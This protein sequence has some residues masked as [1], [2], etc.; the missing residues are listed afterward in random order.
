MKEVSITVPLKRVP[1]Q[2]WYLALLI[3]KTKVSTLDLGKYRRITCEFSNEIQ[4]H[5]ALMHDGK[6]NFFINLNKDTRKKLGLEVDTLVEIKIKVDDSKY[7]MPVPE[8]LQ[9]AWQL[10][11]DAKGLFDQL[12]M[13]KQRSLIHIVGK[14]KSSEK[15]IEKALIILEYLKSVNG[16]LDYKELNEAF[17]A[18]KNV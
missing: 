10:D 12:S 5:C 4:I 2:V 15:R 14:L 7:G 6:G 1:G 16:Q 18:S 17:K 13:G 8:E 11:L 3:P 9:T